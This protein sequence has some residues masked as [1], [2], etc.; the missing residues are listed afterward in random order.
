MKGG[1]DTANARGSRGCFVCAEVA[2][3]LWVY[4]KYCVISQHT[5]EAPPT[6]HSGRVSSCCPD[7]TAEDV[8]EQTS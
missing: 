8:K 4:I 6:G 5:G 3:S 2:V 7:F 1:E